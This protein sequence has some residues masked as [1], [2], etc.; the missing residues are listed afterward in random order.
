MYSVI[1]HAPHLGRDIEHLKVAVPGVHVLIGVQTPKGEDG[2]LEAHKTAVRMAMVNGADKVFVLEDDCWFTPHFDSWKW[3][4]DAG[5]AQAHGY[6]VMC[7]GST[8]TYDEKIVRDGMIEVSAF[9]SAH[10]VVYFQSGYE[11]I[12]QA[13]QPFD[14]SLGRD[15]GC[16]CVLTYPFVAV[17]RQSYS[18][19][20]REMVNYVPLYQWHEKELGRTLGIVGVL[21]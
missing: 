19:I 3:E 4:T 18:G 14:W 2:C 1:L 9:H 16:R 17:Q 21:R 7:G 11:K 10:C 20:L 13:V 12:L 5:W 15:C 6:D 8:R